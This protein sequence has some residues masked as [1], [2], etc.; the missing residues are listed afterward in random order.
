M[1]TAVNL[2]K[3][4]GGVT[5]LNIPSIQVSNGES[6][7]LVGN[8]GA[9]KTTFF[10][11][12][13]DLIEASAGEVQID[14]EKVARRD[15]WKAKVGSFL[16]ESFLIDFLTPDEYFAFTAKVY[17]KSEGDMN[18]FLESMG[19]FFHGEILGSGKLIRD[20]SKGNQKK[21]G[22]AAALISDPQILILDEPFTAL[23]PTSQIRLKRLLNELKTTRN[24]TMLISSHDLNHVTE[25]CDRIVVLEKGLVVNDIRT[26]ENTLKELESYFAV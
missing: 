21:T 10:R 9:G 3:I 13:L 14:G 1:I 23:D 5:V 4:Y 20:L 16:D 18:T 2:K 26:S 22:I 19:D 17:S 25:V 24:M 7:G 6:F 15:A 8:N 12:I 11:L